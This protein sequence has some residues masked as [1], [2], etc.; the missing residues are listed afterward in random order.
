LALTSAGCGAR[1]PRAASGA[2][3][4]SAARYLR[5]PHQYASKCTRATCSR[6]AT[7]RAAAWYRALTCGSRCL[8]PRQRGRS[9]TARRRRLAVMESS[10]IS[11]IRSADPS[12]YALFKY[13]VYRQSRRKMLRSLRA[14]PQ[15]PRPRGNVRSS[16]R[17]WRSRA[18]WNTTRSPVANCAN[19]RLHMKPLALSTTP[20]LPLPRAADAPIATRAVRCRIILRNRRRPLF[21]ISQYFDL[22]SR[23]F[24]LSRAER[25]TIHGAGGGTRE[26]PAA[27]SAPARCYPVGRQHA[28][29]T[30]RAS[31]PPAFGSPKS[32]AARRNALRLGCIEPHRSCPPAPACA[33]PRGEDRAEGAAVTTSGTVTA[34]LPPRAPAWRPRPAVPPPFPNSVARRRYAARP[35]NVPGG[36]SLNRSDP[37]SFFSCPD[38]V[39]E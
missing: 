23:T 15:L 13:A 14:R 11:S 21:N 39:R 36:L 8:T 22:A 38:N 9:A 25:V 34:P 26:R 2:A 4:C 12:P 19:L 1:A 33:L 24:A 10:G 29:P 30:E 3:P 32:G 16:L 28:S 5:A 6:F 37:I 31:E 18:R 17:V 7:T 20:L 27:A 35:L